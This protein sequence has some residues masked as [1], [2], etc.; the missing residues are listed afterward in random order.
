M[1]VILS[2]TQYNLLIFLYIL[3]VLSFTIYIVRSEKTN[4]F[5]LLSILIVWLIPVFGMLIFLALLIFDKYY[6][7]TQNNKIV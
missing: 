1:N 5:K 6:R 2:E 4:V 7:R 3:I